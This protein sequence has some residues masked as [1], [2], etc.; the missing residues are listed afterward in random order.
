MQAVAHQIILGV[1]HKKYF[2]FNLNFGT[3]GD[4]GKPKEVLN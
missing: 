2:F 3:E 4:T 1:S